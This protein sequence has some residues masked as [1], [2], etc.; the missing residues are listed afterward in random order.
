MEELNQ[1][2]VASSE[3]RVFLRAVFGALRLFATDT[4]TIIETDV[5]F[6]QPITT[7]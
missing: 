5:A 4:A 3:G 6:T 1:K 7:G 2:Q